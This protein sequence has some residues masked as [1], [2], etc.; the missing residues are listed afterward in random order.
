MV[1][2]ELGIRR[3]F[4]CVVDCN[5]VRKGKPDPGLLLTAAAQL[6]V[7]M[8]RCL[9]L[10]DSVSGFAAAEAA[11]APYVVVR[12]GADPAELCHARKALA[13]VNDFSELDVPQ[14][15]R[16]AIGDHDETT[17]LPEQ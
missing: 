11:G 5:Q 17:R 4:R 6:G 10:E 15:R 8:A 3:Y 1:L 7:P 9:V 13:L 16:W 12:S 2:D 14:M